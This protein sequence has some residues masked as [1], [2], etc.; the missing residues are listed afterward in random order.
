MKSLIAVAACCL[1]LAGPLLGEGSEPA[2]CGLMTKAEVAAIFGELKGE[3]KPDTGLLEEKQCGY[4]NKWNYEVV[5]RTNG[6][7]S[8]FEVDPNGK[9]AQSSR[10][11][12]LRKILMLQPDFS[13]TAQQSA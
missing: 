12:S 9:F 3:P 6:K 7:E 11:A 13:K 2:P 4:E 1:F 5:V 8:G 10:R